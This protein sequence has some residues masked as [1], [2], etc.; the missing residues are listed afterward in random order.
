VGRREAKMKSCIVVL[1]VCALLFLNTRSA[2]PD[3]VSDLKNEVER[4]EQT[5]DQLKTRLEEIEQ[6]QEAQQEAQTEQTEKVEELSGSV[7][8]VANLPSRVMETIQKQVKVGSHFKFYLAD[9][10][11]GERNN[12]NQNNNL[13]AGISNVWLY[14]SKDLSDWLSV[15]IVPRIDVVAQA[16]PTLGGDISRESN[17]SVDTELDAAFMGIHLPYPYEVEM[18]FG[19]FYPYF[20][21]EYARQTWWHEQYHGNEG[22]LDLESWR[23][24]GV[25]IYKNFDFEAFSL[26]VYFYPY[27]NGRNEESRYVDNNGTKS[28]LLHA[29]PEFFA[30]GSSIRFPA[31]VG[32]GRWDDDDDNDS[33]NFA[34][35]ANFKRGPVDLSG[36]YLM[37]TYQDVPLLGEGAENGENKGYYLRGLY[38]FNEKWKVLLKWSD[39]KLFVPS[40]SS[41]LTDEYKTLCLAVNW[42]PFSSTTIIPQLL[43]VDADRSDGSE[44]LKY[45]RYTLGWRTTF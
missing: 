42:W 28:V 5:I 41:L 12:K 15:D 22:L 19:A 29:A 26:P 27:L 17:G 44:D 10:S 43:Y 14:L 11:D 7:E 8:E 25:E 18:K 40:S 39:V 37:R 36:E 35:G 45:L 30:F 34:L 24:S 33:W 31:S 3:E 6:K 21:E 9:R 13:S 20:S 38:T 1:C 32:W 2:A 4:L 23:A 16:T